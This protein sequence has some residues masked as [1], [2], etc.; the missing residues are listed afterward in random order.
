LIEKANHQHLFAG[1]ILHDGGYQ[2]IHF[3][4]IDCCVAAHVSLHLIRLNAKSPPLLGI[5]GLLT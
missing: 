2:T 3:C 1:R 4:E 5:G